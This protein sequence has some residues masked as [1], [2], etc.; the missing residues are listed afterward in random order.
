MAIQKLEDNTVR[1]LGA[2]QVLNDPSALI[3]ELVDNA[4]DAK[5]TSIAIEIS[6][7]TLDSIQVRD[8]GHGISPEDRAMAAR[9]NCTSKLA[10]FDDLRSIGG[11]TLGF[12]GQALAAAAELSGGMIIS[13]RVE[14]EE[15]AATMTINRLGEVVSQQRA[16]LPVGTTVCVADFVKSQP[17]RRQHALKNAEKTLKHIKQ[18]LQAYAFAR[19]H[20]RLSFRVL[21]AKNDKGNWMYAP[22]SGAGAEDAAIKIMGSACV[23][24]CEWIVLAEGGYELRALVPRPNAEVSKVINAGSFVSIDGRPVSTMRGTM[25]QIVKI[26]REAQKGAGSRWSSAKD[27][28]INLLISCPSASYDPNVEPSKD[29]VLF[30]E[31]IMLIGIARKLFATVYSV[32]GLGTTSQHTAQASPPQHA[33]PA[34]HDES[35]TSLEESSNDFHAL[36]LPDLPRHPNHA[37]AVSPEISATLP[38]R[39]TFRRNMYGCDEEDVDIMDTRPPTGRT[40]AEC[41]ELRQARK[42]ITVSNP[43]VTAKI[44]ATRKQNVL[45]GEPARDDE[46]LLTINATSPCREGT[47]M[48]DVIG[49]C[50][51]TPRPS[52]PSPS[53]THPHHSGRNTEMWNSRDGRLPAQLQIV[54]N[55]SPGDGT[56]KPRADPSIDLSD[57]PDERQAPT[58]NNGLE[59]TSS[60]PEQGTSLQSI[61]YP[62]RRPRQSPNKQYLSSSPTKRP[63]ITPVTERTPREKVWFDHLDNSGKSYPKSARRRVLGEDAGLVRQGELEDLLDEPRPLTPPRR[64]QDIRAWVGSVDRAHHEA[65]SIIER[66]NYGQLQRCRSASHIDEPL[67]TENATSKPVYRGFVPASDLAVLEAHAEQMAK[68]TVPPPKRRKLSRPPSRALQE[69]STNVP[70]NV[71]Q[72]EPETIQSATEADQCIENVSTKHRRTTDGKVQRTKSA[73]LPLERILRGQTMHDLEIR[74]PISVRQI[75]CWARKLDEDASLLGWNEHATGLHSAF[76]GLTDGDAV[77]DL[78]GKLRELMINRLSDGE[79]ALDLDELVANALRSNG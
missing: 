28:F 71:R 32:P 61:P 66:R 76:A 68:T 4:L 6:A 22:K 8:N 65:A 23:T 21:K 51:P 3:K 63:F 78:S 16:S 60:T 39:N 15:V 1:L 18:T 11:S 13:T 29:D 40:E 14:G 25:K 69:L 74:S 12:R 2:S 34:M 44:N 57:Q 7:N 10:D 55:D 41:E 36:L 64:N 5:A 58:Y 75:S 49:H 52:S 77:H 30:E 59:A 37:G 79:M 31:P 35:A 67:Q 17:V 47:S 45:S 19:P 73:R 33:S 48:E 70:L 50:L 20:V 26:F 56:I 43:W 9:P 62:S 54:Q 24:Q 27:P 38:P 72:N 53:A 42:D 46:V